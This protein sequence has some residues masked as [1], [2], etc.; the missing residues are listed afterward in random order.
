MFPNRLC[1]LDG[2]RQRSDATRHKVGRALFELVRETGALPD[3]AAVAARAGVGRRTVFRYFEGSAALEVETARLLSQMLREDLPTPPAEGPLPQRLSAFVTH[4]C[5]VYACA[6]PMRRLIDRARD[7]GAPELDAFVAEMTQMMR[8][9][10]L[11][12]LPELA[13]PGLPPEALTAFEL[14]TGFEAWSV[15]HRS[16]ALQPASIRAQMEWSAH[17]TLRQAGITPN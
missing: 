11:G 12:M 5:A 14:A 4:R 3:A 1:P 17:A 13:E 9:Q 8:A 10:L 15:L 6:E 2:R 7:R 16:L